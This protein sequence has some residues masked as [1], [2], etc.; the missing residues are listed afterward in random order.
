MDQIWLGSP[1]PALRL[2]P[3]AGKVTWRLNAAAMAWGRTRRLDAASW[4]GIAAA[5]GEAVAIGPARDGRLDALRLRWRS[6][7]MSTGWLVWLMPESLP[8]D[9]APHPVALDDPSPP[10]ASQPLAVQP[11]ASLSDASPPRTA[12]RDAVPPDAAEADASQPDALP[13]VRADALLALVRVHDHVGLFERDFAEGR[14]RWDPALLRLFG[15]DA[16]GGA[17]AHERVVDR[18]HPDD[19][20]RVLDAHRRFVQTPGS[21]AIDCRLRF[22]DGSERSV[23]TLIEVRA[24]DNGTVASM[25][26]LVLDRTDSGLDQRD[27]AVE[28]ERAERLARR[29]DTTLDA[30]GVGVWSIDRV[31]G[32]AEWS[33][34]MFVLHGLPDDAA[35]PDDGAY[36]DALVHQDDR[37]AFRRVRQQAFDASGGQVDAEFRIVRPDGSVR[38]IEYRSRR[39]DHDGR[40]LVVGIAID[41]T[42]RVG[43]RIALER[44]QR[45]QGAWRRAG[46][47]R[48]E[49]LARM[50]HEL[51][52][53]LNAVLGFAQLIEHDG[54]SVPMS[55]QLDRVGHIREAGD[56][57]LRLIGEVLEHLR[58]DPRAEDAPETVPVAL[59]DEAGTPAVDERVLSVLYIEDNP[60]NVILVEQLVAM[61]PDTSLHC[62][63]TGLAGVARAALGAP[64][65]VLVD[66]QL[67]DI[68]GFE[69][70][71]RLRANPALDR[72][73]V[74]ALSANGMGEDIALALAAGFDDYWTK[75]IDFRRFLDGLDSLAR[76]R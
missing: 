19:R 4:G 27:P 41:A 38:W 17:P 32:R 33:R 35:A 60:V 51:R 2:W 70:L 44:A 40:E 72:T 3:V 16:A 45:E 65:V 47:G 14:D 57:L 23:R 30:A 46:A 11:D 53:P 76:A 43:Q 61:R 75:P 10:D 5:L 42:D 29:V 26:G 50:S 67:P 39:D 59:A 25:I 9:A 58:Y 22:D 8:S 74:I 28:R 66:M 62:A 52:T 21:H 48:S 37:V 55:V 31:S 1:S 64:D 12:P 56:Q 13:H 34:H 15:F 71:R 68:D 69:V 54:S 73:S 49:S 24:D 18:I 6:L 63:A 7:P 20:Q 36:V